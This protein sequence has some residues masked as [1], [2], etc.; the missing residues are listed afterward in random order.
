MLS[1]PQCQ[2]DKANH[3][4]RCKFR[5][6]PARLPL[7]LFSQFRGR[8]VDRIP[9][10]SFPLVSVRVSATSIFG[11]QPLLAS[12]KFLQGPTGL[13]LLW[14]RLKCTSEDLE[15]LTRSDHVP[16]G[17]YLQRVGSH[18]A[19]YFKKDNTTNHY[20]WPPTI[21]LDK[22]PGTCFGP[23]A[24]DHRRRQPRQGRKG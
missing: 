13:L 2:N 20:R 17:F 9:L 1:L 18:L 6:R 5:P 7:S 19:V 21:C 12:C 15:D 10:L 8:N 3:C 11:P 24:L 14:K 16:G 4:A 23:V 22:P